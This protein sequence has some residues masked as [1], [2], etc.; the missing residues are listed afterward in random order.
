MIFCFCFCFSVMKEL[1]VML[2]QGDF[3][4]LKLPKYIYELKSEITVSL[5][6]SCKMDL[7][8]STLYLLD[9]WWLN[10]LASFSQL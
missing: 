1:I 9:C 4:T 6:C 2:S 10:L 8:K 3:H 7:S 5:N